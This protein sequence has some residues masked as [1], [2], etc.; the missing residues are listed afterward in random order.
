MRGK[1]DILG[2]LAHKYDPQE[3]LTRRGIRWVP[4]NDKAGLSPCS[5][6]S[7]FV[8][9]SLNYTFINTHH[10]IPFWI[11]KSMRINMIT[12]IL[13]YNKNYKVDFLLTQKKQLIYTF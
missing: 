4:A 2:L 1:C 3:A 7:F 10:I 5:N 8:K 6:F 13:I 9:L 12:I 11:E